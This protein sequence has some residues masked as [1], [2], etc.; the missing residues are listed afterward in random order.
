MTKTAQFFFYISKSKKSPPPPK[1]CGGLCFRGSRSSV[2]TQ[3]TFFFWLF[4]VGSCWL[5]L[6]FL[7][8]SLGE[9]CGY[10]FKLPV[11]T[12]HTIRFLTGLL[13]RSRHTTEVEIKIQHSVA[14]YWPVIAANEGRIVPTA[15]NDH[16][17]IATAS[18]ASKSAPVG[19]TT[20]LMSVFRISPLL[21]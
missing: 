10:Q 19:R 21:F 14:E 3:R 11:S 13:W 7:V 17:R 4:I 2:R 9:H 12:Q 20:T 15:Q 1:T 18:L 5:A 16:N 8:V 6:A